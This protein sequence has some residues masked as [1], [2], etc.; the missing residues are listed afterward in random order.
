MGQYD[1]QAQSQRKHG[2]LPNSGAA[3]APAPTPLQ[4]PEWRGSG[5]VKKKAPRQTAAASSKPTAVIQEQRLP[6]DLQQLILNIFR[7]AF[8]VSRDFESW[9]GTLHEVNEAL[10]DRDLEKAFGSDEFKEGYALRWSPSRSVAYANVLACICDQ[11]QDEPWVKTLLEPTSQSE[12]ARVICFGGGAAEIMAFA[13]LIRHLHPSAAGRPQQ[14]ESGEPATPITSQASSPVLDLHLI[15]IADWSSV[16]SKLETGIETPPTLS[17]YASASARAS[18]AAF[19]GPNGLTTT[20]H[21]ADILILGTED[22]KRTIGSEPLVVTFFLTLNDLYTTSIPKTTASLRKLDML[23]PEGSLLVVIDSIDACSSPAVS[24]IQSNDSS[25]D[26]PPSYPMDWLLDRVL[27]GK[28][29]KN[30]IEDDDKEE[31]QTPRWEKTTG[32]R[33]K[34]HRLDDN[35]TYPGSLENMRF[36]LHVFRRV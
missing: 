1:R 3:K 25:E 11:W 12:P 32:E 16:I 14:P 36:Q 21:Q 29:Q 27:L 31:K 20:F 24:N 9:K 26:P 19:L 28:P 34:Q 18:N 7:D 5:Y 30:N 35:L 4:K 23:V 13:G 6:I 17:K 8:L 33:M 10:L 15:D 2:P 22:L